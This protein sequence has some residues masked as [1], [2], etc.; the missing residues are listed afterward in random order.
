MQEPTA[1]MKEYFKLRTRAHLYLVRKWSD[2]I[3]KN[4]NDL[5]YG[6]NMTLF[7][8]ERD[9]H[10]EFKFFEPEYTPYLFITW[11]YRCKRLGVP[12]LI[13]KE[14]EDQMHAATLHHIKHHRHHPEFWTDT[15]LLNRA[16]RD[17]PAESIVDATNMP[18]TYVAAMVADWLAMSE[19][20]ESDPVDWEMKN[21]NVRW[22]FNQDQV[23]LIREIIN[24]FRTEMEWLKL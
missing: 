23:D 18:L 5:E 19:E 1:E 8:R 17:K 9:D 2:K 12:F 13:D 16:D 14:I 21:V 22:A 4:F 15:A 6:I 11:N 3:A 24:R 20:L 7:E 10:D